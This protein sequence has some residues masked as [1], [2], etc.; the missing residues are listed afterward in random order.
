MEAIAH[1]TREHRTAPVSISY[2]I[3]SDSAFEIGATLLL[4][5]AFRRA[6]MG[7]ARKLLGADCIPWQLSG[8]D[9]PP[10]NRHEHAFYLPEDRDGDGII[11]HFLV[12]IGGGLDERLEAVLDSLGYILPGARRP[13]L[14]VVRETGT[15]RQNAAPLLR[16]SRV[17]RSVTPYL[18]PWFRKKKFDVADQVRRECRARGLP[19]PSR[20]TWPESI[21]RGGRTWRLHHF[22]R[23]REKQ[24]SR[25]PDRRGQFVELH[26]DQ[27]LAG[28][29]ALGYACHYGLG[30]FEPVQID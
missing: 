27:T 8:H 15:S 29:L 5:E 24:V 3:T 13:R 26:F 22:Q 1:A 12:H 21:E 6:V 20:I 18:H 7:H 28:P 23:R 2:R 11:D 9:V 17:W 10:Q 14:T 4:G 16:P 30:L 25:Q 19:E